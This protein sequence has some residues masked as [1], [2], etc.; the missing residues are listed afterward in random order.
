MRLRNLE[1]GDT[2]TDEVV[3]SNV[4]LSIDPEGETGSKSVSESRLAAAFRCQ[5]GIMESRHSNEKPSP[6]P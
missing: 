4:L 2:R 6:W 3:V 1:W 5:R